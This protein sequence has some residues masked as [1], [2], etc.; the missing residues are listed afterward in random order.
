MIIG[1]DEV[2]RGCL[3]GP[4]YAAAVRFRSRHGLK[5]FADSKTLTPERRTELA[6]V[7]LE[8]HD[9][10]IAFASV[11]E[12]EK[13]N[14]LGASFIAMVRAIAQISGEG[15]HVIVDGKMKIRGLS[16]VYEQT[17]VIKGDQLVKQISAA[18]IVAKVTRDQV[19]SDMAT[20]YPGYG[21]EIHKGYATEVHRLA[22]QTQ[23]PCSLHRRLFK[24]VREFFPELQIQL[25]LL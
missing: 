18:S 20:L 10:G 24:G 14:I 3:A 4:V 25:D 22:L 12:I 17:A 7:I 16:Q 2:G 13:H 9:V 19:M 15:G 23:G 8:R 5:H 6:A 21:F 1:V 11:D